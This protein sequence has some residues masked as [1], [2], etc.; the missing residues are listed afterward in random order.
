MKG[1]KSEA[2]IKIELMKINLVIGM[3]K[4][5]L[6]LTELKE[7]KSIRLTKDEFKATLQSCK[8]LKDKYLEL[9]KD[10]INFI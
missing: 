3:L 2:E 7:R 6:E 9:Y 10:L 4:S 1:R 8:F 5:K